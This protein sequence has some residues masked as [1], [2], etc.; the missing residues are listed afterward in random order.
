MS[1][2]SD[3]TVYVVTQEGCVNCPAA[4]A[5]VQEALEDTPIPVEIVDLQEM[6]PDFE[7]KLLENQ[8]FIASTPTI[9]VENN[10]SIKLLYSGV[11]PTI[12]G[13]RQALGVN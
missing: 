12:D 3:K 10:G 9:L 1:K 5:I 11:V 6:D 7:F 8:V 4:K 13:V 2:I